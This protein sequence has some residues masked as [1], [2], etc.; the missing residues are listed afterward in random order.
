MN[1]ELTGTLVVSK[2]NWGKLQVPQS[3]ADGVYKAMNEPG[4]QKPDDKA[5]ISVFTSEEIAKI[6]GKDAI[7]ERGRD[8]KYKLGKITHVNPAGWAEMSRVWFVECSSPELSAL[9]QSY[10][11]T[12]R[13]HGSHPFHITVA[14][15]PYAIRKSSALVD[16]EGDDPKEVEKR[17]NWFQRNK[18][19]V[20]TLVAAGGTAGLI[21]LIKSKNKD[22]PEPEMSLEEAMS[23]SPTTVSPETTAAPIGIQDMADALGAPLNSVED[24]YAEGMGLISRY[25]NSPSEATDPSDALGT[26]MG[27][28]TDEQAQ[29][30]ADRYNK[31][32][33]N[34]NGAFAMNSYGAHN[35]PLADAATSAGIMGLFESAMAMAK[36]HGLGWKGAAG[37]GLSSIPGYML[38]DMAIKPQADAMGRVVSERL[39]RNMDD[40]FNR[41]AINFAAT[42]PT[43]YGAWLAAYR[44]G[45]KP[46]TEGFKALRTGA[47]AITQA[48]QW[49]PFKVGKIPGKL[50]ALGGGTQMASGAANLYLMRMAAG[51]VPEAIHAWDDPA[52]YN[53]SLQGLYNDMSKM[54]KGQKIW[55]GVKNPRAW[56]GF[57]NAPAE[58]ARMNKVKRK[59]DYRIADAG[60]SPAKRPSFLAALGR[61]AVDLPTGGLATKVYDNFFKNK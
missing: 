41:R 46:M 50:R 28:M 57:A 35:L 17:K 59:Q 60:L 26:L 25:E 10:G 43:R 49:N 24:P 31:F 47:K 5:H 53:E 7:K 20:A 52:A 29:A 27:R 55:E 15:K 22:V 45:V 21:A 48:P 14:V 12:P 61:S 8:F 11:L 38:A 13:L 18:G 58:A 39:T 9:R 36:K 6:G 23:E 2:S 40:G 51:L 44:K 3:I 4:I 34:R 42:E 54:N 19:L 1:I 32:T 16:D 30:V 56:A 33:D 37:M